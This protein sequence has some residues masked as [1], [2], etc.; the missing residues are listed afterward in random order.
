M[1]LNDKRQEVLGLLRSLS[2]N[3]VVYSDR[4]WA[5]AR[6]GSTGGRS[7]FW[8]PDHGSSAHRQLSSDAMASWTTDWEVLRGDSFGRRV[9]GH[10]L[11]AEGAAFSKDGSRVIWNSTSGVGVARCE[12]G[13][14]STAFRTAADRKSWHRKHKEAQAAARESPGLGDIDTPE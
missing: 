11:V 12:C 9:K 14:T 2:P 5:V 4:A 3:A 8:Y 1:T 10:A 6:K 13:A 7:G